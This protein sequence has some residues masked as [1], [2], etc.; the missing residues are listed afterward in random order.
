MPRKKKKP[1]AV[2]EPVEAINKPSLFDVPT[3]PTLREGSFFQRNIFVIFS[4]LI[5]L[6]PLP[7]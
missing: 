3:Q 4:F 2:A 1:V 7:R 5:P 6:L